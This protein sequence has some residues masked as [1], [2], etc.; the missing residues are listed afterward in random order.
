[1]QCILGK[2]AEGFYTHLCKNNLPF[3][4]FCIHILLQ[5]FLIINYSHAGN[6]QPKKEKYL[7]DYN[8][9]HNL[10]TIKRT[11]EDIVFR[12]W[13]YMKLDYTHLSREGRPQL[14]IR[15]TNFTGSTSSNI[16]GSTI[17]ATKLKVLLSYGEH[18]R[19]FLPVETLF[20]FLKRLTKGLREPK[21]S[22]EETYSRFILSRLDLFIIV[23]VNP[24]GRNYVERTGNYCWRGTS[25]GVDLNRNFDWNYG[26]PGSKAEKADEEYRG[27]HAFSEPESLVFKELVSR[28]R[29]DAFVSFHSG[30]RQIYVP[31]ADTR[32]KSIHRSP[33]NV[34]AMLQLASKLSHSTA[35]KFIYGVA[36]KINQYTA[37]GTIF[38][39]M[40]GVKKVPFSLAIE[41][42]G[43]G[44][45][46]GAQC[47]DLFNPPSHALQDVVETLQP[48][49]KALFTYLVDWK[50]RQ[51][52]LELGVEFLAPSLTLGYV[53]LVAVI[54]VTFI[55]AVY[56]RLPP[57]L[58]LVPR[59]RVVSL[60]TLSSTFTSLKL[61]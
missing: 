53:L 2:F 16:H 41:L 44:D 9:Y 11:V 30:I 23:M 52:S 20:Y 6:V 47:F 19:E 34:A 38:D 61:T 49:Y 24:D 27:E 46:K 54:I 4:S 25:T 57:S 59:R 22:P 39:Y 40:A 18:S 8:V 55:V 43:E 14:L 15:V 58:R 5:L 17:P 35:Y 51:M 31:F 45:H 21:D 50:D 28:Y 36:N 1:M 26:G 48:M 32:S 13:D 10:S 29:F 7:P 60:K 37:D 12:N 3:I 42:W 56:N 33:E